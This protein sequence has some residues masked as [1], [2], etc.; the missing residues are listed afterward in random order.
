MFET[1]L[2]FLWLIPVLV[3]WSLYFFIRQK[4]VPFATLEMASFKP[5][6]RAAFAFVPQL[7][8]LAAL[9]ALVAV[10]AQPVRM[11][12]EGAYQQEGIAI[13]LVIDVSSSMTERMLDGGR[14]C[15]KL[16]A[17]KKAVLDFTLGDA[18]GRVGGRSS[19]LIGLIA[20]ARYA[21]TLYPLTFNR[22]PLADVVQAIEIATPKEDGTHFG[23]GLQMAIA[24][25]E[26]LSESRQDNIRSRVIVFLTD[27]INGI[28]E[29]DP[30]A[31]AADAKEKGIILYTVAF[32]TA[33]Q[34]FL[35]HIAQ[36]TGGKAFQASSSSMLA[37]IYREI[38]Q[39]EKS[40]ITDSGETIGEPNAFR[41]LFSFIALYFLYLFLYLTVFRRFP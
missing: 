10:L 38:D 27:G 20:F 15:T 39:L 36:L 32:A 22:N 12:D 21:N 35:Q 40:K 33:Q 16:T 5:G 8:L 19:D 23:A 13:E 17:V 34:P 2:A 4:G 11:P 29:I 31:M 30:L 26:A 25:L 18:E 3:L 7:F 28:K 14:I 1:P 24:R 9:V 6:W 41:Y 37:D